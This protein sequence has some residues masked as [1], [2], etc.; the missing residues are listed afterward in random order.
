MKILK[1]L[2][3][4]GRITI[5]FEIRLKHGFRFNDIVS[6][7]DKGD[8]V[9]IRREKLCDGCKNSAVCKP[10]DSDTLLDFLD[11]LSAEEQRAALVH[12]SVAWAER[13]GVKKQ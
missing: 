7:E 2:G 8:C 3:K 13:Q 1:V 4:K 5:P 6:F 11:G 12:L 9:I 10:T